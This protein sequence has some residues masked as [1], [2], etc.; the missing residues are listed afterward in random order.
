MEGT[1][2]YSRNQER[3]HRKGVDFMVAKHITKCVAEFVPYFDS[4]HDKTQLTKKHE[5]TI[6]MGDFNSKLGSDRCGDMAP[7]DNPENIVRNQIDYIF[8]NKRFDSSVLRV[9]TFRTSNQ[10]IKLAKHKN[11]RQQHKINEKITKRDKGTNTHSK[12]KFGLPK[13]K[14]Q[15]QMDD[16][17]LSL[18]DERRKC[19]C[20]YKKLEKE[21]EKLEKLQSKHDEFNLHK[22]LKEIMGIYRKKNHSALVNNNEI[23]S[24]TNKAVGPNEIPTDLLKLLEKKGIVILHKIFNTIYDIDTY[25]AQWLTSLMNQTLKIFLKVLHRRIYKKCEECIS[26]TQFGFR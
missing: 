18:M 15:T 6:K 3:N 13:K 22:K 1:L 12:D 10:K 16:E 20:Q 2:Y 23:N 4:C 8:I 14:P 25:L 11:T 5:I 19:K 9:R 17:I 21:C 7:D 24:K 26:N